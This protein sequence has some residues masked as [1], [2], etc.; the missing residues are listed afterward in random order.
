MS[1]L[2]TLK[3]LAAGVFTLAM[4]FNSSTDV[5]AE[6][7]IIINSASRL[8][9]FYND[10]VKVAVYPLGLGKTWTPT[11]VGYY[12][13]Q[14]KEINPTWVD[15]S[16][17][18]YE[19]PSG[20]SNPLGYRWMR[21][22]GNYGIHGT[23][24]PD[25]I[26]HYVSNGCIRKL[27]KDVEALFDEVEVGTPVDITY[28]RVVVEKVSDGNV[29]YY[30]YPDGYGWQSI[31]VNYVK[32]WLEPYGVAPFV[33]DT[34]IAEKINA[35]NGEP[36]YIG[37]PYN[38]EVNGQKIDSMEVNGRK[39]S[40]KAVIRDTIAY[41]PAVPLAMTLKTKLEWR[42]GESTLKT[43][44]GEVVGYEMQRQIYCNADDV[45]MLFSIDGGLQNISENPDDGKIFRFVSVEHKPLEV[46]TPAEEPAKPEEKPARPEVKPETKNNPSE[47]IEK[48]KDTRIQKVEKS[49]EEIEKDALSEKEIIE[50][51]LHN[52]D[53]T[54]DRNK[55][56]V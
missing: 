45:P 2:K 24:K 3:K 18:E 4:I 17:P 34:E 39:F 33:S 55:N 44:Y 25:S 22:K 52:K 20:P 30:I 48:N 14:T 13:I 53:K 31:D 56:K 41:I 32:N 12:S 50:K 35:S 38:I 19:V 28:N 15:P 37:K 40:S 10:G 43:Q 6:K 46:F 26:G 5:Q 1:R 7:R 21:I 29:A 9:T 27:E 23:N 47:E 51:N 11:P 36:T 42:A 54:K 49:Q 16:D 8:M